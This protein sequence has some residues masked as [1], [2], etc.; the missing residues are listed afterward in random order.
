[1]RPCETISHPYSLLQKRVWSSKGSKRTYAKRKLSLPLLSRRSLADNEAVQLKGFIMSAQKDLSDMFRHLDRKKEELRKSDPKLAEKL[2]DLA[3]KLDEDDEIQSEHYRNQ[4]ARLISSVEHR[5][6][7]VVPNQHPLREEMD[8]RSKVLSEPRVVQQQ[9]AGLFTRLASAIRP[10]AP[11]Q[12]AKASPDWMRKTQEMN[13]KHERLADER[14]LE[15]T[16][17]LGRKIRNGLEAIDRHPSLNPREE[18]VSSQE[19]IRR[20]HEARQTD[21]AFDRQVRETGEALKS[22]GPR[23]DK[24]ADIGAAR[25]MSDEIEE[26]FQGLDSKIGELAGKIPGEDGKASMIENVGEKAKAIIEKAVETVSNMF[27]HAPSSTYSA[28]PSP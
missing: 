2:D 14:H 8:R 3:S 20:F 23:R 26:R 13:A 17:D 6:G 9:G 10:P 24:A 28:S 11:S 19:K 25:D 4:V 15:E 21:P 5:I 22:Y 7:P 27:R 12:D 16:E 18:G 1:M